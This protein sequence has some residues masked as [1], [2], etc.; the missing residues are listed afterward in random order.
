MHHQVAS[1]VDG[2]MMDLAPVVRVGAE[3]DQVTW[4]ELAGEHRLPGP[5]LVVGHARQLDAHGQV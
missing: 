4:E 5:V 3:E 1:D 2:D